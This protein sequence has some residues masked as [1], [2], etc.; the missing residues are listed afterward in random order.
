VTARRSPL[1]AEIHT[2]DGVEDIT[3][4]V[5]SLSYTNSTT[6]GTAQ[7]TL[8]IPLQSWGRMGRKV[9]VLPGAW[10]VVRD[11]GT[12]QTHW[13]GRID[14]V[15]TGRE[16]A[17]GSAPH[18]V[19]TTPVSI[20]AQTYEQMLGN[21]RVILAPGMRGADVPGA[22]YQ[23]KSWAPRMKAWMQAFDTNQPGELLAKVFRVLAQQPLPRSLGGE[24]LGE[25]V[26]VAWN[27]DL[28]PPALVDRFI[29]V[30]GLAIQAFGNMLP[31]GTIWSMI[32]GTFGADPQLVELF[33]GNYPFLGGAGAGA[34]V[35]GASTALEEVLGVRVPLVYRMAPL[36]VDKAVWGEGVVV[37]GLFGKTPSG[38]A[39]HLDQSDVENWT[40]RW[41]DSD[42]K[43]GFYAETYLQPQSQMGAYGLLGTP[44]IDAEDAERHGLRFFEASWPFFPSAGEEAAGQSLQASIDAVV[45]YAAHALQNSH[46]K[47]VGSLTLRP[48][49]FLR[50]GGW[51]TVDVG[52]DERWSCYLNSVTYH[53]SVAAEGLL[54]TGTSAEYI[55]G[56]FGT[57]GEATMQRMDTVAGAADVDFTKGV[58]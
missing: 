35:G 8:H 18:G 11:A 46:L 51:V 57:T 32:Q 34:S 29:P 40:V 15:S 55:Q 48:N 41:S 26:P 23:F 45:E 21:A 53:A 16:V 3:G 2:Y 19:T 14:A 39:Q 4:W 12:H 47:G 24:T 1:R 30:P 17:A 42:R 52:A 20:S 56:I 25:A 36:H 10:L 58:V 31:R 38:F 43:N 27:E 13:W 7:A 33:P 28:A 44:I 50:P 22:V 9:P 49:P 54:T 37:A 5:G 6:G